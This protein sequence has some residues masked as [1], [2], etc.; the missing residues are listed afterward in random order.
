MSDALQLFQAC[1]SLREE[2][3]SSTGVDEIIPR[4]TVIVDEEM[5]SSTNKMDKLVRTWLSS[6]AT[7]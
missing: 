7:I 6:M 2:E 5:G 3:A 1:G 4:G